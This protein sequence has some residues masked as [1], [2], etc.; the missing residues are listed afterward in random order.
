M[1]STKITPKSKTDKK[2]TVKAVS[3]KPLKKVN[4]KPKKAKH[5]KQTPSTTPIVRHCSFCGKS[6]EIRKNLI[7][8]PNYIFICDQCIEVCVA[9]LFDEDNNDWTFRLNEILAGK[10]RFLIK[11]EKGGKNDAKK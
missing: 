4:S 2:K 8:G 10:N 1:A 3:K 9:V 11:N 5:Q 6:S 7:A